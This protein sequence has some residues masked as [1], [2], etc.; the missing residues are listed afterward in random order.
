MRSN[1]SRRVG[2]SRMSVEKKWNVLSGSMLCFSERWRYESF[3]CWMYSTSLFQ[4]DYLFC[5]NFS[6]Q[7]F[8]LVPKSFEPTASGIFNPEC[9][10]DQLV[11][12]KIEG[13]KAAS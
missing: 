1:Q 6:R 10:Q 5:L 7:T 11:R 13:L 4:G 8:S 12:T 9:G 3:L 2:E